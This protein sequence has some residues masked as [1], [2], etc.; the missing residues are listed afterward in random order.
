L[1]GAFAKQV[2]VSFVMSIR[3]SVGMEQLA[4][5]VDEILHLSFSRKSVEK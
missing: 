2:A 4:A 3:L 5:T 1:L